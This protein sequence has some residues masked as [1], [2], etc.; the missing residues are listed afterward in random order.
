MRAG[1]RYFT[2]SYGHIGLDILCAGLSVAGVVMLY[3]WLAAGV[4]TA[5]S[6][7]GE[8]YRVLALTRCGGFKYGSKERCEVLNLTCF[9]LGILMGLNILACVWSSSNAA[10]LREELEEVKKQAARAEA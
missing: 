1:A 4:P 5:E 2:N 9:S 6:E 8:P 7:A 3:K 10:K